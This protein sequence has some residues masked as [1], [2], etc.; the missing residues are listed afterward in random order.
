VADASVDLIV[1]NCAINLSPEK[2]RVWREAF[3]V[4]KPGG[5]LAIADVV[6]TKPLP[7][8]LREKLSAIGACI[9]GAAHVDTLRA[10]LEA[11]GFQRVEIQ[12]RE[13]SRPLISQWTNDENAG[14]FVVSA[15][16]TASKP[17]AA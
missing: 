13:G 14:Y 5:R 11:A 7:P 3:R 12:E 10:W 8:A 17:D 6:A 1:S 4:L 9:G 2:E 15:L 16:L